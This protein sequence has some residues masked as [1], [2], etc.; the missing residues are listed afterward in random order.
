M[1]RMPSKH[2]SYYVLGDGWNFGST[3]GK[4]QLQ[5]LFNNLQSKPE[6]G[7]ENYFVN[8]THTVHAKLFINC[9]VQEK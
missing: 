3:L 7:L 1:P 5:T 2:Y 4:K 9:P 8:I 6:S